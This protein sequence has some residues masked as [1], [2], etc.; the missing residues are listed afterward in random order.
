L[1]SRTIQIAMKR[2]YNEKIK[3][4]EVELTN[5]LFQDLRDQL[6]LVVM[7]SGQKI[8]DIYEQME[9]PGEA[10]FDAREWNLFKPIMAIGEATG[11]SELIQALIG[12]AN[13]AY[14]VKTDALNDTS[15]EN[16]ILRC[17]LEIVRQEDWYEF[18]AIHHKVIE[19]IK[20][21]G[22]N[23]G[24]LSKNRL[25]TLLRNL[26]VVDQKERRKV[27]GIKT[28]FHFLRPETVKRVA[29]NYRVR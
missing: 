13:E 7:D 1:A 16:V 9:R 28:V 11:E 27:N 8:K 26:H 23:V 19:F 20:E 12:F 3:E 14:H 29:E 6:F 10:E 18:E 24:Q 4:A 2:S 22:L 15:V 17:L 5:R 25:G 21:N